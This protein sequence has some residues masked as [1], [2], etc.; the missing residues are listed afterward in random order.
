MKKIT[1]VFTLAASLL[2]MGGC[3]QKSGSTLTGSKKISLENELDSVSYALGVNVAASMKQ[4]GLN[5]VNNDAFSTAF[6]TQMA[7]EEVLINEAQS[8]TILDRYFQKLYQQQMLEMQSGSDENTIAGQKFLAKNK[9]EEGVIETASGLQYK[10]LKD[11]SGPKPAETDRVKV[12]YVGSLLDGTVFESSV[13]NGDPVTFGLNQVIKG[14]TE[15]VQ[16]MSVGA[17]YRFFIPSEMAYGAS[18]RPGGPIGPNMVLI[19]D[20]DLLEI[21]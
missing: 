1:F 20:I 2:M 9:D 16:L 13:D 8:K 19:F 6:A 3:N 4:T 11:A 21:L 15:G 5:E 14:W 12:H 7:E 17:K 18:P 10:V